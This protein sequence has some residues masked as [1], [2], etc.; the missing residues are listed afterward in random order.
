MK[1]ME[2]EERTERGIMERKSEACTKK[3][4]LGAR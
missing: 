3:K 4:W 2:G 1:M